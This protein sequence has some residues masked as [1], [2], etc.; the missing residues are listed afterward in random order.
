MTRVREES[1]GLEDW[2]AAEVI[3]F[4]RG[5]EWRLAVAESCTGGL[6]AAAL[7]AIPG[8]SEVLEC[9]WV[10]YSNRSKQLLLGLEPDVL[11]RSGAVSAGAAEAMAVRAL[12]ISG[13]ELALSC[14]GIAGPGGA[15]QDKPV[16]L[17]Y[18]ALARTGAQVYHER[19]LFTG[20]RQQ[21]R[22]AA[23][24]HALGMV[25]RLQ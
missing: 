21:I 22:E 25:L 3:A 24:R 11:E 5:R 10:V 7:T 17:V 13:C 15:G 16:G 14:T 18:M 4:L 9:G 20:D 12:S 1:Q 19:H 8:A 2:D 6:L 23:V